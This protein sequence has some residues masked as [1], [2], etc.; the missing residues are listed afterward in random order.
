MLM[1]KFGMFSCLVGFSLSGVMTFNYVY[2]LHGV[3]R[4]LSPGVS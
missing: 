2:A 1:D 4:G 3:G